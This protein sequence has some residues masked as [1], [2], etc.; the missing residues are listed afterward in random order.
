VCCN[1]VCNARILSIVSVPSSAGESLLLPTGSDTSGND[2]WPRR[3][4]GGRPRPPVRSTDWPAP[5]LLPAWG[6]AP[7]TP[8]L[9]WSTPPTHHPSDWGGVGSGSRGSGNKS[10]IVNSDDGR[11]I[12][13][14]GISQVMLHMFLSAYLYLRLRGTL[15]GMSEIF[16]RDFM[17]RVRAHRVVRLNGGSKILINPISD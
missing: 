3:R 12:Y 7:A 10:W 17:V 4:P 15:H 13:R 8:A 9:G 11:G 16:C 5:V 14:S 6:S 1:G 2:S